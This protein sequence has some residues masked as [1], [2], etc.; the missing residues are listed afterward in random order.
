MSQV[1]STSTTTSGSAATA[2]SQLT[3]AHEPSTSA[4]TLRA[5]TASSIIAGPPQHAPT[6]GAFVSE[7]HHSTFRPLPEGSAVMAARVARCSAM[8]ASAWSPTPNTC[9]MS[10]I[11]ANTP[12]RLTR[13]G[14]SDVSEH[15]NGDRYE[16][17]PSEASDARVPAASGSKALEYE[18]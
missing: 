12:S 6:N 9:P 10:A 14:R 11:S 3:F 18:P 13:V 17:M 16:P 8:S 5:P 7:S 1:A 4:K 2:C 15:P